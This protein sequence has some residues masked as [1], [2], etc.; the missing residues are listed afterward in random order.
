MVEIAHLD[1]VIRPEHDLPV[2]RPQGHAYFSAALYI[3]TGILLRVQLEIGDC[4]DNSQ[5]SVVVPYN[6]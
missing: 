2:Q 4:G 6:L 5:W 1:M 3:V